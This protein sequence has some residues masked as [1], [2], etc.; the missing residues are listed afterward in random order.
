MSKAVLSPPGSIVPLL[1]NEA[2]ARGAIEA[3]L[4]VAAAYP[5]TPSTE[6]GETL[7]EAARELGFHFEWATNEKV[8][9]EVAIGAAWSGL[10]AMCFMKHVGVNVAADALFTLTYAGTIGGLVVVSADDP[11]AHSSQNEQDNRHYAVAMGLPMLEPST[12]QE[13]KDLVY[14]AFDLSERYALPFLVRST[15]RISH[16]R[17][18]VRLG[19]I[20]ERRG[21]GRFK[22]P[23]PDRYVQVG[24]IA[25]KHHRELLEKLTR[26]E[27][28]LAPELAEVRGGSGDLGVITSGVAYA[29][30]LEAARAMGLDVPILKLTM[31][32]PLPAERIGEFLRGLQRVLIVE[33]LDPYLEERV[34]AIAKDT[35]PDVE[36]LGKAQGLLPRV[37]ELNIRL[38]VGAL[39]RVTGRPSPIDFSALEE[40][41]KPALEL[42]VSRPPVMCPACPHRASGYVIRRAAG[43]AVYLNDIGCYALLFQ[44]PF[45]LGDVTHA[46]GSGVGFANGISLAT[47]Q[48][49]VALIGD[50]TFFHAGIPAL[51][52]AVHHK[53]KFLLVVLD[54]RI[55]AMTGHQPHPGVPV[56]ATGEEV[57]ALDIEKVVRGLGVEHVQ[58]VDPFDFKAAENAVREA[59]KHDG[60]SVVIMRRECA[61][62]TV[63][64]LRREGVKIV[65]YR[66]DPEKCTYCRV[67]INTYACPAFVD[68]GKVV[69]IDPTVCFG[70]GSCVDVCPYGAIEPMEGSLDWRGEKIGV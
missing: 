36:I 27:R 42:A 19:E 5:G 24:A 8:A 68:T 58:V 31:T 38:V 17:A 32:N 56:S 29:Y 61:L 30:V 70:C 9:S 21:K 41:A 28:E 20:R 50:S 13:A 54:N 60:V 48:K 44:R 35:A 3:G 16:T 25:R 2:I 59:M 1:G 37:G 66:V 52:N 45:N 34:K 65:P 11:H 47:D 62:L 15:T 49:T 46:M 67:C 55:T 26:I 63:R 57:P 23:E 22:P 43:T 53:R 40:R 39:S 12:P 64:R 6:I 18:P 33:E 69:E 4:D 10:R 14:R 51:I 7:A